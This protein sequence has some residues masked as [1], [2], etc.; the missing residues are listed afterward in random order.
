MLRDLYES[1][2]HRGTLSR[3][4]TLQLR[5]WWLDDFPC[6]LHIESFTYARRPARHLKLIWWRGW[7][8]LHS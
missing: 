7:L 2:Y 3:T 5:A 8:S 4:K 6:F 1:A